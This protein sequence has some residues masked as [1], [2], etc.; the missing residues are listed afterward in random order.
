MKQDVRNYLRR[1]ANF[2]LCFNFTHVFFFFFENKAK[3][4]ICFKWLTNIE[5][6]VNRIKPANI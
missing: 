6:N 5:T 3:Y 4:T 1:D 2:S